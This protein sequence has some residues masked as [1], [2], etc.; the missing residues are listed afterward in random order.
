MSDTYTQTVFVE[1]NGSDFRAVYVRK[2][3]PEQLIEA[4]T[5]MPQKVGAIYVGHVRTI[6]QSPKAAYVGL[7]KGEVGFLPL[8]A[9]FPIHEGQR[10]LVQVTR[11]TITDEVG[12]KHCRLTTDITLC[13]TTCVFTPLSPK[14]KVSKKIPKEVQEEVRKSLSGLLQEPEGVIVRTFQGTFDEKAL[15]EELTDLRQQWLT[16]QT[17]L[18]TTDKTGCI[19]SAPSALDQ[20][21]TLYP[22]SE[23]CQWVVNE[24]KLSEGLAESFGPHVDL[25]QGKNTLFDEA[26]LSEIWED[27]HDETISLPEGGNIVIEATTACTTIDVNSQGF[28]GRDLFDVNKY[29]AAEVAQQIL[30]RNLSG[31]IIIDFLKMKDTKQRAYIAQFLKSKFAHHANTHVHGFTALG[32][33]E[34]SRQAHPLGPDLTG[35]E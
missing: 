17:T 13:G 7:D 15:Q 16:L 14:I 23:R 4:S 1:K 26:G 8:P 5:D 33:F 35:G 6:H 12:L 24:R 29:A 2:D 10:I 32:F 30:L 18:S 19:Q 28:N 31:A 34:L 27:I 22:P 21:T 20:L 11:D 25:Y 9:K 3:F